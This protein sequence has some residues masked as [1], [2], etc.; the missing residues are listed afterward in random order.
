MRYSLDMNRNA[1]DSAALCIQ[2]ARTCERDALNEKAHQVYRRED[3]N[4]SVEMWARAVGF[5]LAAAS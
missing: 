2:T 4:L 5:L 1:I 3:A